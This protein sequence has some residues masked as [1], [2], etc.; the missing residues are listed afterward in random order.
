MYIY[1]AD[2]SP[3]GM[4]YRASS[5][6]QVKSGG[7]VSLKK[8]FVNAG[9]GAISGA[10]AAT[11]IGAVGQ[12]GINAATSAVESILTQGIDKGFSKVDYGEAMIEAL[13]GGVSSI[14]NGLSKG[15]AKHLMTQGINAAKQLKS[16]GFTK[17]SKYYYSQTKTLFCKPLSTE[18]R[19]DI[20]KALFSTI[21]IGFGK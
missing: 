13:E 5:V 19:S 8:V 7:G 21:R 16:K 10:V 12:F 11:G 6:K 3:I 9:A 14:G 2:G 17:T 20:R 4:Q 18:A 1:D 15:D